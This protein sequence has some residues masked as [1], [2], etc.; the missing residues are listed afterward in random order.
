M[1]KQSGQILV[2]A[3]VVVGF[4]LLNA[5]AIIGGATLYTQNSIYSL[6]STQALNL[7]EAGVD[8]ALA[9][10]NKT[11]GSYNGEVETLFGNGSYSVVV[12]DKGTGVKVLQVTGYVPNKANSKAKKTIQTEVFNGVGTAF[13][14]AIQIG[15]GGL[16]MDQNSEVRGSVY[17]N[18][19]IKLDADAG[20]TGDAWV[21]GGTAPTPDQTVDCQS[22]TDFIFGKTVNGQDRFDAAQSFK[23]TVSQIINK[24][25]LKL[26][27]IGNPPNI[28]VRILKDHDGRPDEDRVVASGT[29][30][31]NLVTTTYNF[32]EVSFSQTNTLNANDTYWI[33]LDTSGNSSNYW[34]WSADQAQSYN[35]GTASWSPKWN[36][37][38]PEWHN[39]NLDFGFQTFMGGGAT[40]IDGDHDSNSTTLIGGEAHANTLRDLT[41]QK[42]AYYQVSNDITAASYHPDSADPLPKSFPISEANIADWKQQAQD[43]G[44]Y[45]GNINNCP[46]TM[47]AGKYIGNVRFPIHCRVTIAAPLWITGNLDV[48]EDVRIKLDPGFGLSSGVMMVDGLIE[49][50]KNGQVLGSGTAGSY[51]I[52]LSNFN[53]RDDG[54]GRYAI[55]VKR[56]GNT[57]VLYSNLGSIK[58]SKDNHITSITGWKVN[59][60]QDVIIEYDQGLAGTFFSFGPSGSYSIV[61]GTYEVK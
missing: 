33:L 38:N 28:A 4:V 12:T 15:E 39:Q 41:I 53:S 55:N 43:T 47:P 8:K 57:G 11:G 51:L 5:L 48:Q 23:P 18:G 59:A 36:D 37:N 52:L 22:C 54:E 29:L 13:N 60:R 24:V 7:A 30:S 25:T 58:L 10:L 31:A 46:A 16:K 49:L 56:A 61:K 21:A 2:L 45:T 44:I 9:S 50:D 6:Q 32:I 1:T 40:Y 35:R 20:I 17:S 26:K 19:N 34:S 3:I 14:Y 42:G 27:K